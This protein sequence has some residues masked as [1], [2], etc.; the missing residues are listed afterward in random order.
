MC[1]LLFNYQF[2]GINEYEK[3][4][5]A[6]KSIGHRG[7][8]DSGEF[9]DERVTM[10]FRRL[11]IIDLA[12]GHQPI[13]KDNHVLIFNGEIYNY[14]MLKHELRQKG[15]RFDNDSDSLVL[16]ASLIEDGQD[17]V[18]KLRGMYSF[19]DYNQMDG[20]VFGARDPFGIKPLYYLELDDNIIFASEYKSLVDFLEQREVD[21]HSL[22]NYLSFQYVYDNKTMIESI[23]EIPPGCS[24]TIKDNEL[25]IEK[26]FYPDFTKQSPVD[27]NMLR[28]VVADSIKKHLISDVEVGVYLSGGIDSTIV[29]AVAAKINPQITS[30]SVGFGVDGYDELE[31]AAQTAQA[32]NIKNIA[33]HVSEDDFIKSLPEVCYHLDDPIGDASIIGLYFLARET[34]KHVK[35]VLSGEGSDE[36]FGGYNIYK[37]CTDIKYIARL[38]EFVKRPLHD[39]AQVM[40]PIKGKSYL[41]RS[42]TPLKDRY[43]GN[44]KR[45]E[46]SEAQTILKDY[47]SSNCY[48]R[49]LENLYDYTIKN[50]FD[51][52]TTMQYI[53]INSWLIGDILQKADKMS[54][55]ASL[56]LRVP[57]LDKEVFKVASQLTLDQKISKNQT[58]VLLRQAFKD[59]IP[60]A[61]VKRRK[62]GFPV[63]INKWLH[64]RLGDI[65][66][67]TILNANIDYLI[68]KQKIL[69]LL[70]IH[71]TTKR[72]C[73]KNIWT[74]FMFALWHQI[75]IE[76]IDLTQLEKLFETYLVKPVKTGP[77]PISHSKMS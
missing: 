34:A 32:L 76:K 10:V 72:D 74:V 57:F 20:S 53:D 71:Q 66:E 73:S 11:S 7:P 13:V 33:V 50:G 51:S 68:D 61:V 54:M 24:F 31:L 40:P 12:N 75:Y 27:A 2:N 19:I 48:A 25:R 36:L 38:P 45:F 1:G 49:E 28:R 55:A 47:S 14:Q 4:L 35:V 69:D 70:L 39:L 8:D 16:L 26:Y 52:V 65:V 15:Y 22:Q 67:M 64:S 37:E 58:K 44:A 56:E 41:M 62:L 6:C 30:F 42:T 5:E 18:A 43:I 29:A 59:E 46:N 23:K 3:Y 9:H 60:A 63:P 21:H 17:A 77:K